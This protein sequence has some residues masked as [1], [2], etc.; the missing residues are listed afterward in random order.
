MT[1]NPRKHRFQKYENPPITVTAGLS[2]RG[3]SSIYQNHEF[4]YSPVAVSH[5]IRSVGSL[6]Q[7]PSTQPNTVVVAL[8]QI[9]PWN[10]TSSGI[11]ECKTPKAKKVKHPHTP[12]GLATTTCIG[13]L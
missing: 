13:A 4:N 6:P 7:L 8:E 11:Q 10:K 3:G 12:T 9:Q 1:R 2:Y 5:V